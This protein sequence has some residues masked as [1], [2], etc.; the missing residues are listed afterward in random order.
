MSIEEYYPL[1]ADLITLKR[2]RGEIE[3]RKESYEFLLDDDAIAFLIVDEMGRNPGNKTKISEL[4]DG[5]NATVEANVEKVGNMEKRGNHRILKV[6]IV[7][8]TGK[9]QFILWNDEIDKILE[10]IKI[11]KKIKIINGYVRDNRYGL[12]ISLGKW[13]MVVTQ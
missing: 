13:G 10:N 7:D 1:I 6:S 3:K 2:F 8:E 9:C 12:Q 11:G 4:C 5:I